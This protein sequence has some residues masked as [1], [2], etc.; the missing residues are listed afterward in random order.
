M[1]E[2]MK[3][4]TWLTLVLL[5]LGAGWGQGA[6]AHHGW[7]WVTDEAFELT[8]KIT[9]VRLGNPHGEVTLDVDG[10]TWIVEIGQPRRNEQ[11]GLSEKRL[12]AG[13][14]ITVHGYRFAKVDKLLMRAKRLVINGK[15]Y[16]LY[17]LSGP[18]PS[19]KWRTFWVSPF[20]PNRVNTSQTPENSSADC[21]F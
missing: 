5:A 6:L 19:P 13:Q 14:I 4:L 2:M 3:R 9:A 18:N 15:I 10:K 7:G 20:W 11:V 17:P 1:H 21:D 12:S 16:D 8:G